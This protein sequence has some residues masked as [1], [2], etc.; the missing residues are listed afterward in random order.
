MSVTPHPCE[1][2]SR[3]AEVLYHLAAV[4]SISGDRTG[5]VRAI[6]VDGVRGFDKMSSAPVP[7]TR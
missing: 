1:P 7:A 4:I 2:R 6:N 3:G 5:I